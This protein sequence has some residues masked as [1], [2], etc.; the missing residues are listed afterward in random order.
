MKLQKDKSCTKQFDGRAAAPLMLHSLPLL[1]LHLNSHWFTSHRIASHSS[2]AMGYGVGFGSH[3]ISFHLHFSVLFLYWDLHS[4]R[5]LGTASAWLKVNVAQIEWR[6]RQRWWCS[7]CW[8][9]SGKRCVCAI[10]QTALEIHVR[11]A[12]CL[13]M[14]LVK[15][16]TAATA[17]TDNSRLQE[18]P[19]ELKGTA[20]LLAYPVNVLKRKRVIYELDL[21]NTKNIL[22]I[23]IKLCNDCRINYSI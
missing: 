15:S 20:E 7:G 23:I 4:K 19:A 18:L 12:A 16:A 11:I 21:N 10:F 8:C 1:L 2:N 5:E 17:A 22:T 3:R 9:L 14:A 6:W 13:K